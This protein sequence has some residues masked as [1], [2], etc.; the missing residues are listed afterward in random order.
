MMKI[1]ENKIRDII[2]EELDNLTSGPIVAY[3]SKELSN[4]LLNN[5]KREDLNNLSQFEVVRML[6]ELVTGQ[7]LEDLGLTSHHSEDILL[8][9]LS[10]IRD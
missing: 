2:L 10:K 7:F 4:K 8:G 3:A 6:D 9:A 5:F 1:S